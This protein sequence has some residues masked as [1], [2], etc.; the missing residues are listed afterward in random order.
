M[1]LRVRSVALLS[2]VICGVGHRRGS[3]TALL[4]LWHR[5]A[6]TALIGP[7]AWE[8]PCAVNVALEKDKK[9]KKR[10]EE[11]ASLGHPSGDPPVPV[12]PRKSQGFTLHCSDLADRT[13]ENL[14]RPRA[15]PG[16]QAG[17]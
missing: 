6:A 9:K 12:G 15:G 8:P 14:A 5:P 16:M 11:E 13:M 3:D 17:A 7:L 4:W 1:R 10:E 2:A